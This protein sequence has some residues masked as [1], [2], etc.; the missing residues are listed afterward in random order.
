MRD[1]ITLDTNVIIYAFGQPYDDRKRVAKEVVARCNIIS[2]Q[3]INETVCVLLKKF[4]FSFEEIE[5]VVRFLQ[6]RFVITN[7]NVHILDQTIKI[8]HK[9]GFSFWDSM[10]VAAALDNHCSILYSEDLHHE[11]IIEGKLQIVNPFIIQ[12]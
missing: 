11:Q 7:L 1:K 4:K 12:R 5:K 2:L 9:Y 10:I 3:V 6:Q 8:T